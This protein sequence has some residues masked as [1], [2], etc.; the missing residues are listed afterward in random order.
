MSEKKALIFAVIVLAVFTYGLWYLSNA[1]AQSLPAN[2]PTASCSRLHTLHG[3]KLWKHYLWHL[4]NENRAKY[5]RIAA[6]VY[7]ESRWNPGAAN[8]SSS[9]RGLAQFLSIWYNGRWHFDPLNPILSLRIM[10]YVWN[11]PS[12]GGEGNWAL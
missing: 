10:V 5:V 3:E 8:P 7:R 12:L 6:V 9:A 2:L 4:C 11:R 1:Q